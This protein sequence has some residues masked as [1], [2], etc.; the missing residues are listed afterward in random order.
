MVTTPWDK[1]AATEASAWDVISKGTAIWDGPSVSCISV[2]YG[3]GSYGD[4]PAS[5]GY[6][7]GGLSCTDMVLPWDRV[8]D[9]TASAWDLITKYT[10]T[11]DDV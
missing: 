4:Y 6:G 2:G 10:T 1:I 5:Y 9:T 11:W 8:T 7:C 3:V